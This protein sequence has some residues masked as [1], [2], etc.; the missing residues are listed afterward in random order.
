[1]PKSNAKRIQR[2]G[3]VVEAGGQNVCDTQQECVWS[4]TWSRRSDCYYFVL[5]PSH[6][7]PLPQPL[8]PLSGFFLHCSWAFLG[9]AIQPLE[10]L[11]R[12]WVACNLLECLFLHCLHPYSSPSSS[13]LSLA[14]LG[15]HSSSIRSIVRL[16]HLCR[17]M[18]S[19]GKSVC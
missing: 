11:F 5:Q 15:L 4:R 10:W 18:G 13:M 2:V 3:Q 1:M 8:A 16:I 14:V 9:N 12:T 6:F 19:S 7:G 17:F